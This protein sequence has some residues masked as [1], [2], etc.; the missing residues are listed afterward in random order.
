MTNIK[1]HHEI[2]AGLIAAASAA[3]DTDRDMARACIAKAAALL[4]KGA[5]RERRKQEPVSPQ[6]G[7][8]APWQAKRVEE[9]VAGHLLGG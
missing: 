5:A 4:Q 8:L 2:L 9:F 1:T 7:G 6:R 3:L